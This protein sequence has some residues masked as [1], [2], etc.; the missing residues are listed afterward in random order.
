MG[1]NSFGA[2][3]P[4]AGR[5]FRW[6]TCLLLAGACGGRFVVFPNA[7]ATERSARDPAQCA[8]DKAW[9]IRPLPGHPDFVFSLYGLPADVEPVRQIVEVMKANG[10]GNGF[11]PG[12]APRSHAKPVFDYLASVGWPVVCYPGC[13]DMQIDGGRCVMTPADA[14]ALA[15][16]DQ[17][18]VFTAVQLGEWGYYLHNLSHSERW[19]R[20]VYGAEFESFRHLMKPAGLAGY[21]K[22][23]SGKR[24]CFEY[25][26]DYFLHRRRDMLDRLI[27]VT[28]HSHYEAYA[29]EW[30][31]R[32]VGLEV[33][34]NIA[35]TQS[36]LAFARGA[37]RQWD[38]PWSVQISPW[39]HGACTTSGPLRSESGNARGLD[40]GHSLSFYERMWLH[41][42]FAGAAMVTPE[43]SIAIF[44]EKAE[45]PWTLTS[46]GRKGAEVFAFMRSHDRGTPYTPVAV[47]IDHLAG[48][49]GYMGK[50]WGILEPTAGDRELADLLERQLFPGS[51]HIHSRPDPA[52]PEASYL[53]PTPFGESFDVQLTSASATTL[54]SYPVLLLAG[55]IELDA[56]FMQR[57]GVALG[58]GSRVLV[59]PR[60]AAVLGERLNSLK[61]L[62]AVEI[63]EPWTNP[64]TGRPAAISNSRLG[65]FVATWSPVQVTGDAVQ[66]QVNR[67]AAGWVV[68]LINNAGV[69]KKPATAAEIDP[70][71]VARVRLSVAGVARNVATWR[72]GRTWESVRS[73]DVVIGPGEV[74]YVQF[75]EPR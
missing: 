16:M 11:D 75:R 36:K 7:R 51:D 48:Y 50:P 21:T 22:R 66:Y 57:L 63:L 9:R 49:N 41:S 4:Y 37:S 6:L 54:S 25:V 10:L 53:R 44:F 52:N 46:H 62:G 59:G 34:E 38:R 18:G 35:F 64:A 45:A 47:V 71:A 65:Q 60:H 20:D 61:R 28:G 26:R 68:E 19:W 29:A 39:F 73:V 24:E 74:E 8:A 14:S 69:R 56:P 3:R 27:S 15:S 32:C 5:G 23:P 67:N 1:V 42:W 12:P 55:D 40:A 33:G 2:F 30:G 31:A 43:N 13:A 17:R 72:S 70:L 58:K